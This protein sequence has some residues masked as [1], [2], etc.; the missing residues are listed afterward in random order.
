MLGVIT[1][2]SLKLSKIF[3]FI[4]LR[5]SSAEVNLN[6]V[7]VLRLD[8]IFKSNYSRGIVLF[9]QKKLLIFYWILLNVTIDVSTKS[10]M[11]TDSTKRDHWLFRIECVYMV[12]VNLIFFKAVWLQ[13]VS[14]CDPYSTTFYRDIRH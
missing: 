8:Y 1:I 7:N 14:Y 6:L 12:R 10:L 4:L 2:I 13:I 5:C 3:L 9:Q 11:T